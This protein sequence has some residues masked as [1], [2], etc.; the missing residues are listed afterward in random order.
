MMRDTDFQGFGNCFCETKLLLAAVCVRTDYQ[1]STYF[2][3]GIDMIA[4]NTWYDTTTGRV[5]RQLL[6]LKDRLF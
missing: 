5:H 6:L 4:H 2:V 3:M 1:N